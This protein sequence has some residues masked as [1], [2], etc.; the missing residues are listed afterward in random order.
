MKKEV[1][2]HQTA[3]FQGLSPQQTEDLC[4]DL[5]AYRR[6]YAARSFIWMRGETVSAAG[7]VLRGSVQAERVGRDGSYQVIAS[8]EEGALFGEVLMGA[9]GAASPF[10]I[11]ALADTEVLFLP[12]ENMM[13]EEIARDRE[14]ITK[15]RLNLLQE[16]SAKYWAQQRRVE[17]MRLRSLRGK[18]ALWLLEM[19]REMKSK[20]VP[21]PATREVWAAQLG[22]NRSALSRELSRMQT[23]GLVRFDRRSAVLLDEEALSAFAE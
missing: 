19:K 7:I 22:V 5:G 11:V 14:A 10:D 9:Q 17:L 15:F 20:I 13:R 18:I 21:L 4:H 2:L 16:I 3:L 23:D 8:Q 1:H 12:L 6:K